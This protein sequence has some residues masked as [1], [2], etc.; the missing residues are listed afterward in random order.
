MKTFAE[1]ILA[2]PSYDDLGADLR[3]SRQHVTTLK[4]RGYIPDRYWAD[5]VAAAERRGIDL[6]LADL[7][8]LAR[9]R[10]QDR[11]GNDGCRK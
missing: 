4:H 5:L 1:I 11:S 2:W 10:R 6:T 9:A 3:I 7:A 8:I